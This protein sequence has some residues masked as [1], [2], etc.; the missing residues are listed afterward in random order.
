MACD[1]KAGIIVVSITMLICYTLATVTIS[2]SPLLQKLSSNWTRDVANGPCCIMPICVNTT[3][4]YQTISCG[5]LC[6][7]K[8]F[9]LRKEHISTP[10]YKIRVSYFRRDC[11]LEGCIELQ[12]DCD[13][14]QNPEKPDF[15]IYGVSKLCKDCY[16]K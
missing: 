9:A 2:G 11:H 6:T 4:C 5:Y 15:S 1:A 7:K 8:E 13:R 3:Q 14:C 16:Y 10:G 12:F